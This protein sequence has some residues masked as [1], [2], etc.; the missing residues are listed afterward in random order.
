MHHS[1]CRL[2]FL[3]FFSYTQDLRSRF[4]KDVVAAAK[5]KATDDTISV[6]GLQRVL[7]NIHMQD[8]LTAQEME[9]IFREMGGTSESIPAESMMKMI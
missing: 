1:I 2:E 7:A 6:K 9:I 4:T 3:N 8:K 5:D